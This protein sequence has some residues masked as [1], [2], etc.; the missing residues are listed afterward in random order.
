MAEVIEHR[1]VA[2]PMRDGTTLRADV[3]LPA[4]SAESSGDGTFP[5]LMTRTPYDKRLERYIENG[6]KLAERGYAVVMQDVRGRHASDGEFRPGFYSAEHDDSEDGYDSVE[7]V[8]AQP[9]CD[10]GVGTFG[11]SYDGWTQWELAHMRPPHLKAM[12]PSAIAANLLDRELSGVLRLGRVLS[13]TISNLS[14]DT[15]RRAGLPFHPESLDEA[16]RLWV[17]RDRSKWLWYL[18]LKEIPDEYMPN[19]GEHWRRWLD[20]HTGDHFGFE[21]RHKEIDVPVLNVTGWYDQQIG[22]TKH[23][24]GMKE[25]GPTEHTRANQHL[26]I[27]PWTHILTDMV[28]QVG[29][30]DFGPEAVRDYYEIA[31]Q[32]YGRWLKGV[33]TAANEWPPIQLFTMGANA[34]RG[35]NEWPL[36]RTRY[37]EFYLHSGGKANTAGGD[38]QLSKTVPSQ[39]PV[40]EYTYDP[41]DPVMTLFSPVGQ[42]EP[43][44]QRCLDG[45]H[46]VL[47]Y[48]TPPLEEPLEVT[49]HIVVKLWIA[50]S[51]TD[52]DFV[53]KLQDVWP[54]GFTQELCHGIVRARYRDSYDNPS[55]LTPGEVYEMTIQVNPTSNLFRR[56]HRIRLDITSSDFPN[57][58][59]NHNTG[60]NDY[61]E[62]T[63]LAAQQTVF[64]DAGRPSHVILPVITP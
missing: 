9:W 52:T 32:W 4:K 33:D 50:S 15:A 53:A 54:D 5:A 59:R 24:T 29:D 17:E 13:W 47:C 18:P 6:H 27:G 44:D 31:D 64:H 30:V 38:G 57:F 20:D 26:I 28:R 11:A 7:W 1:D 43:L 41:R 61:A 12:M 56:G 36:A 21:A 10:G 45:R 2:V 46:D 22:M 58:D 16:R 14:V 3:Y 35:E 55:L 48:T 40:D 25:N 19:M 51:A 62:S 34:W 37:T 42:Q 39:E 8:A 60:G 49:G 23:F 63:L